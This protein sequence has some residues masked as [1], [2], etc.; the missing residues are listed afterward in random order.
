MI[1]NVILNI[2]SAS[3]TKSTEDTKHPDFSQASSFGI[4]FHA[5]NYKIE[6]VKELANRLKQEGKKVSLLGFSETE[7]EGNH[8]FRKKDVSFIDKKNGENVS[9]FIAYPFDF[10]LSINNTEQPSYNYVL[11]S[12]VASCKIGISSPVYNK[13]LHLAIKGEEERKQDVINI[14]NYARKV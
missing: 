4:L 2:K 8:F 5:D 6:W 3:L 10:L 11:A 13:T 12:S 7:K 9:S 14:L 1:K